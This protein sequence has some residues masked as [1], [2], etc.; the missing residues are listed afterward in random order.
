VYIDA[1]EDKAAYDLVMR[2]E[3]TLDLIL[4]EVELVIAG[5]S[6]LVFLGGMI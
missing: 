2:S 3:A 4:L 1:C 5:L 6:L